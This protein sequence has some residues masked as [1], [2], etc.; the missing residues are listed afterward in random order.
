MP[1]TYH[2][3]PGTVVLC[4]FSKGFKEPEMVKRRPAVVL[5]PN[6]R[7]RGELCTVV[8][9]SR[10]K[11][12]QVQPYHYELELDIPLPS[13]WDAASHWVKGDM[14]YSAGFHRIDL[15]RDGRDNNGKREYNQKPLSA[16][17]MREIKCCV[18]RGLGMNLLTKHL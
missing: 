5:S 12:H 16:D 3:V 17:H 4:D 6:I 18:L 9:L 2:P 7:A 14:I 1:I 15:I 11:P 13:P 8:A 10:S